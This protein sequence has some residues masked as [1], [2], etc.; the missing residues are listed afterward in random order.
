[1][2]GVPSCGL[3]QT[4]KAYTH[5]KSIMDLRARLATLCVPHSRLFLFTFVHPSFVHPI[6]L[7]SF[8]YLLACN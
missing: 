1:M 4:K 3:V 2:V 5:H 8:L 7:S 6:P